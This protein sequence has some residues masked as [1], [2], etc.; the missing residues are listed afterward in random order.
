L[1]LVGLI[2]RGGFQIGT[3]KE[4]AKDGI[5]ADPNKL[6][7]RGA[8]LQIQDRDGDDV[9]ELFKNRC[10]HEGTKA[11]R[12]GR[13]DEEGDLPDERNLDEAEVKLRIG[14]GGR[15]SDAD[16]VNQEIEWSDDQQAPDAR[17]A[18]LPLVLTIRRW[19]F[20]RFGSSAPH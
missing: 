2:Q 16:L 4:Q 20:L 18:T 7:R 6:V 1:H 5:G 3:D 11:D 19:S 15:I 14:D 10:N 12:V 9:N 13:D 17:D 8:M